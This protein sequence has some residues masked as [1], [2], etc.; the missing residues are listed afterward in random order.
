MTSPPSFFDVLRSYGLDRP[1]VL[2]Q[3][4]LHMGERD[5]KAFS[6]A[7]D[8]YFKAQP[9]PHADPRPRTPLTFCLPSLPPQELAQTASHL[10]IAD[11]LYL[12]DPLY[13][14]AAFLS[15][16]E[17]DDPGLQP[18]AQMTA[19]Y[20]AGYPICLQNLRAVLQYYHQ[21]RELI[22]EGRLVPYKLTQMPDGAWP[23]IS[24]YTRQTLLD[25]RA[26][27]IAGY[28]SPAGLAA[29]ALKQILTQN[30]LARAVSRRLG[31]PAPPAPQ[32]RPAVHFDEITAASARLDARLQRYFTYQPL[33]VSLA[34]F[35][36]AGGLQGL[37]TDFFSPDYAYMFRKALDAARQVN[38]KL[39]QDRRFLIPA[40]FSLNGLR[41]PA[42]L[43][44]PVERV[45]DTITHEP[46][47]FQAFRAQINQKLL[48]ISAPAGSPERE[49]QILALQ[50]SVEHDVAQISLTYQEISTSYRQR[51]S[52]NLA[53]GSASVLVAGLTTL[54]SNLD[55][56][57]IAGGVFSGLSLSASLK[58]FAKEWLDY[59]RDLLKL[60][61]NDNYF[62]WRLI[63]PPR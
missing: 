10:L 35:A 47:A 24:V 6:D 37:S 53:L 33:W 56:L 57:S 15:G 58:E 12:D 4:L 45:L 5:W 22:A 8:A 62:V 55:A 61:A 13:D 41:L 38:R 40:G 44:L 20:R 11:R 25:A 17:F 54:G 9:A 19:A 32:P 60:K 59:Q 14:Y 23:F 29:L 31:K 21:A 43:N 49:Q 7:L 50:H 51:F 16:P 52:T 28:G 63:P 36:I 39:P 18:G 3:R 1:E 48:E 26:M 46:H 30:R 42:L 34:A 27:R 2:D